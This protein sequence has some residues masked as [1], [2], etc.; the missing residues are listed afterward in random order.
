MIAAAYA[1]AALTLLPI[2]CQLGLAAG[3]P[4]GTYTMAGKYPGR[5]PPHARRLAVVQAGI[6]AFCAL[7]VLDRAGVGPLGLPPFAFTVALVATGLSLVANAASP[8]R[9]ERRLWTPVLIAMFL[10]A[11]AAGY[12]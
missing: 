8:S 10:T 11:L 1:Y 12:L 3:A 4:W 9:P 2:G 6:L 5:L 7:A